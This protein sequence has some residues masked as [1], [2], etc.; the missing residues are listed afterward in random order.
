MAFPVT[1]HGASNKKAVVLIVDGISLKELN[2]NSVVKIKSLLKEHGAIGLANSRS[3]SR[4]A[5]DA[6][7][8]LTLGTGV[9]T[10]AGDLGGYSFSLQEGV[11]FNGKQQKAQDIYAVTGDGSKKDGLLTISF[12]NIVKNALTVP[13]EAT[14]GLLGQTLKKAGLKI[15]ALGNADILGMPHREHVLIT[16]D[17]EG[18]TPLG[19][20]DGF[21]LQ[22]KDGLITDYKKLLS[23]TFQ[24]LKK[25]DLLV[26]ELGDSARLNHSQRLLSDEV[27]AQ[28]KKKA[29]QKADWFAG[30]LASNL[31][32]NKD[33]LIIASPKESLMANSQGDFLTPLLV[34]GQGFKGALASNTTRWPGVVSNTDIA[35][36]ITAFFNL[37]T[38][39]AFSGQRLTSKT[40]IGIDRLLEIEQKAVVNDQIRLPLYISFAAIII[41]AFLASA[42]VIFLK[43][44]KPGVY[45]T[46]QF[47]IIA[48]LSFPLTWLI[49][50]VFNYSNIV[51]PLAF[52]LILPLL[53]AWI[54]WRFSKE[55]SLIP[56][57]T[58][59]ATTTMAL[60][61][62]GLGGNGLIKE[63]LL[64]YSPLLGARYY[65]IGNEYMGILI[66]ACLVAI[67]SLKDY[68]REPKKAHLALV[69]LLLLITATVIGLPFLGANVGGFIAAMV[70][71]VVAVFYLSEKKFHY[72]YLLYLLGFIALLLI[73]LVVFDNI[74]FKNSS[75]AGKVF[76]IIKLGKLAEIRNIIMRK[77]TM[78]FRNLRYTAWTEV[79]ITMLLVLPILLI[80]QAGATMKKINADFPN[81]SACLTGAFAGSIAAF[82]FND[83]G[84]VPAATCLLFA[85]S[86]LLYVI[87]DERKKAFRRT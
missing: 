41:C 10:Y 5:N 86:A 31:D 87:I 68:R 74:I 51:F 33:M 47:L 26:V 80:R 3:A 46:F 83:S 67:A 13:N 7:N 85:A 55:K 9:K 28:R 1:A 78:N 14:P 84:V 11:F 59:S 6:S 22:S 20:L 81:L 43:K 54:I 44:V 16:M 18:H 77:A 72:R 64:G 70:G 60:L 57:L 61:I 15:A 45:S 23:K 82:I 40:G 12:A 34:F 66:G 62:S 29:I 24:Y 79:I 73:G 71:F 2:E 53:I 30:N 32:F 52:T 58:I 17:Q 35:S 50:P 39:L 25:A 63:S 8:Y 48:V 42:V 37:E 56:L 75:H 69:A 49:L 76:D 27:V 19:E 4:Y 21:S 36:T 38:P 65:G